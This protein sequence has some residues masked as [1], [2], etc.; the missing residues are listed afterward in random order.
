MR[1]G[2]VGMGRVRRA[3]RLT[4]PEVLASVMPAELNM[5]EFCGSVEGLR[6]ELGRIRVWLEEQVPGRGSDLLG[7]VLEHVGFDMAGWYRRVLSQPAEGC[8][9]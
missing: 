8:G 1:V 7:P 2:L 4:A 9:I 3:R 5:L 6:F